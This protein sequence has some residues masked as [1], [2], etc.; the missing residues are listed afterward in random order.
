MNKSIIISVSFCLLFAS[1]KNNTSSENIAELAYRGDTVFVSEQSAV[2]SKINL[3]TIES[4]EFNSEFNTTGTIKAITGQK[5]EI[6]PLFDGRITRSFVQLGQKVNTGTPLFE[7]Y[8]AE[9]SETVKDYFQSLQTKKMKETNLKRQKDLVQNGVGV[10]KELEEAETDYEIALKD[11]ENAVANLKLLHIDPNKI[12]MEQALK[13]V[14]P[15]AGKV[16]QTSIAVGQYI[17]RDA[18]PLAIIA[19]LSKIWVVA[20]VKEKNIGSLSKDDKVE[21]RTDANPKQIITGTV[22][23]ISELLDEETRSIQVLITC[24]NKDR[25]LKPGMFA[26]VHFINS[27]KESIVIPSTA[28]LQNEEKS[29]VFIQAEK[30]KFVKRT[31]EATTANQ[32]EILVASGLKTGDVIVSEGGIYLMGN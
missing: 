31:V 15:V 10:V 18:E 1:C 12:D 20:Q 22:S 13:I 6:A 29:Y 4:K 30:G 24:D 14:S 28:L 9:F 26:N 16:V 17:K 3:R 25:K 2:N 8:S 21:I 7:M 19:D 27:P 23:H 11:C 32:Q 5:A